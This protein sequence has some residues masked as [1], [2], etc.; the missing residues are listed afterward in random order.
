MLPPR[1]IHAAS[2]KRLL[3]D[4][5]DANPVA[6]HTD[7]DSYKEEDKGKTTIWEIFGDNNTGVR[8]PAE[9]AHDVSL[10]TDTVEDSR[11]Y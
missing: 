1:Q 11:K 10:D 7:A 3:I 2:F 5:V 8:I 4:L 6:D 9:T